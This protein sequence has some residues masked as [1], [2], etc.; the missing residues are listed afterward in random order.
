MLAAKRI[1]KSYSILLK[2]LKFSISNANNPEYKEFALITS[3]LQL[4]KDLEN[5]LKNIFI[6]PFNYMETEY[7][8][9]LRIIFKEELLYYQPYIDNTEKE[10]LIRRFRF[11]IDLANCTIDR[12]G[13][14]EVEVDIIDEKI[15]IV[16]KSL[17]P[18][19]RKTRLI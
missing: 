16:M 19:L 12:E 3:F 9:L 10:E 13:E 1:L 17:S 7:D 6:S 11:L 5:N 4:L 15:K 8:K 2:L 14:G 18:L